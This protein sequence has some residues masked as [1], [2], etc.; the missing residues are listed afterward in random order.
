MKKTVLKNGLVVLAESRAE[1]S[2]AAVSLTLGY[3]NR[4]EP[5]ALSGATHFIEHLLFKGTEGRDLFDLARE[6]NRQGGRMNAVTA[7]DAV[8]VYTDVIAAD[9]RAAMELIRDMVWEST[10]PENEIERERGVILEEIAEYIDSPEDLC[11]DKFLSLLWKGHPLGRPVIGTPETVGNLTRRRLLAWWEKIRRPER[12]IVSVAGGVDEKEVVSIA[13]EVFS[14]C[15]VAKVA[16]PTEPRPAK[17]RPGRGEYDRELEQVQFC[18]GAPAIARS[19]RRRFPLALFDTILGG[20]MGSRLFNEIRER[21]GLAYTIASSST[22]LR[23]E[24]YLMIYGATSED[25]IDEVLALCEVELRR[26]AME[27]PTEE[28]MDTA[29]QQ[30]ER[31]FLLA[32]DSNGFRSGRNVDRELY[33]LPAMSNDKVLETI[34]RMKASDVQAVGSEL[35][36]GAGMTVSLV[37]PLCGC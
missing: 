37:G 15:P 13:K 21:R 29:R 25:R 19:D 11:F 35:F 10:F 30:F 9:L 33:G 8:R 16:A 17:G 12:M 3:G 1:S 24:G 6:M 22:L 5:P 23:N 27:G 36:T 31:N 14:S 34:R 26:L 4:H 32:L 2:S 7:S 18:I 28:E 20:G